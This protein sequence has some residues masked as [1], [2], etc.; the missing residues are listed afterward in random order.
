VQTGVNVARGVGLLQAGQPTTPSHIS[1]IELQNFWNVWNRVADVA[2]NLGQVAS[3]VGQMAGGI[4]GVAGQGGNL[5]PQ[6]AG[7]PMQ[8]TQ[9]QAMAILRH[10]SPVLQALLQPPSGPIN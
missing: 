6:Q 5:R 2:K 8:M 1:E 10:V 3:G 4:A 7:V 9:D